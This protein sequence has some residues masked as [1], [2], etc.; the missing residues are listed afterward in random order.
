MDFESISLAART[1]CQ[2]LML[3]SLA[4]MRS[5][6]QAHAVSSLICCSGTLGKCHRTCIGEYHHALSSG[7]W[8]PAQEEIE[9][10]RSDTPCGTERFA[11]KPRDR[12][13]RISLTTPAI[14]QLVEHLT[15]ELCRYQMVPGSIPGRRIS[16]GPLLYSAAH[17][18][19]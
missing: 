11:S 2:V 12:Q 6:A 4:Q 9:A 17:A 1:H 10:V 5:T 13:Q 14:A 15:V 8:A 3:R 7:A 16:H 18:R 19:L